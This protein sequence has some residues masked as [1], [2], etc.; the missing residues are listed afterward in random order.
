[1]RSLCVF[2]YASLSGV[3]D[4][5]QPF[6]SRMG[7]PMESKVLGMIFRHS[8]PCPDIKPLNNRRLGNISGK[9]LAVVPPR[10]QAGD[11]V[12]NLIGSRTLSVLRYHSVTDTDSA[13]M[14]MRLKQQIR[15]VTRNEDMGQ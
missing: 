6:F 8:L 11:M 3:S 7:I 13:A 4:R 10:A 15:T 12:V 9:R 2:L 14:E 5:G 1:M